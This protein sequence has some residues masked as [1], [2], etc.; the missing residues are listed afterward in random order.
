MINYKNINFSYKDVQI[1][2]DINITIKKGESVAI[3][4]HNGAGKT[5]LIKLL[6]GVLEPNSGT[7]NSTHYIQTNKLSFMPEHSALYGHLSGIELM[8]YFA[9]LKGVGFK[10]IDK[11]LKLV[12]IDFAMYKKIS[13]YSK[14]MK[15]RLMLAQA[16]LS[17]PEILILDEP[18]SGLDPSSR[19]LFSYILQDLSAK[20]KSIILSSH[21][22][23]GLTDIVDNVIFMK[24]GRVALSGKIKTVIDNLDL[25]D[26]IKLTLDKESSADKIIKSI[27]HL[28]TSHMLSHNKLTLFYKTTNNIEILRT[29]VNIAS[30]QDIDINKANVNDAY[31]LIYDK[32]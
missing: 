13:Q 27:Q 12:K 22:L 10:D 11:I 6:I 17:D 31:Y 7:I 28:I 15:Q 4:G 2:F 25:N 8:H 32:L 21:T 20:G 30:I 23:E 14:G 19:R 18:Y 16:L 5:T 3:V 24:K 9:E 1:L 29:I 26:K